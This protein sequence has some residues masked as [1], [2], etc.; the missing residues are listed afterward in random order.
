MSAPDVRVVIARNT[1]G[2]WSIF[3]A[4][5]AARDLF[6][7]R[8]ETRSSKMP[9][10][11]RK[12]RRASDDTPRQ[13]EGVCEDLRG[14]SAQNRAASQGAP[15]VCL[16]CSAGS[17]GAYPDA[18]RAAHVNRWTVVGAMSTDSSGDQPGCLS[19]PSEPRLTFACFVICLLIW[20][21]IG[22]YTLRVLYAK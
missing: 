3:P 17:W 22:G 19:V 11:A 9:R 2:S 13:S 18:V 5:A 1:W 6:E 7:C 15:Y 4:S 20:A 14:V 10:N 16:E 12:S 21:G 8:C